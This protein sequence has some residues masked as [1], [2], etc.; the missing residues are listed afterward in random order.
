MHKNNVVTTSRLI[1]KPKISV[2]YASLPLLGY[3]SIVICSLCNEAL[4]YNIVM[5]KKIEIDLP[6]AN[7][8][9]VVIIFSH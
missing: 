9:Y 4:S 7:Y 8:T 6:Y 1:L 5:Y 2:L 3:F